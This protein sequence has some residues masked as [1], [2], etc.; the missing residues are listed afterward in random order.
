MAESRLCDKLIAFEIDTR[1]SE[2]R[3]IGAGRKM[4]DSELLAQLRRELEQERRKKE[5][6]KG[7][8]EQDRREKEQAKAQEEQ[9]K[10]REE[11][12][13]AQ[14]D[15]VR[16]RNQKTTL[17]EYLH[18]SHFHLYKKLCLVDTS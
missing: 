11:Q 17:K 1:L 12:A 9:A 18:N 10:A 16:R 13:K 15:E 5:Q 4:S 14:E 8:A 3:I 7:R 2:I 6:A